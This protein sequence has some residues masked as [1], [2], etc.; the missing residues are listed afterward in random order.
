MHRSR[1]FLEHS[2]SPCLVT[3]SF[4]REVEEYS[5]FSGDVGTGREKERENEHGLILYEERMLL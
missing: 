1:N 2:P 3:T 4:Q 5:L